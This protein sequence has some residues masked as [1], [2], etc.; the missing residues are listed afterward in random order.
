MDRIREVLVSRGP[1]RPPPFVVPDLRM[2]AVLV[3]LFEA[4]GQA[5]VLLT[6]RTTTMRHHQ[7]DVAFPGG[8]V[9]E[10]EAPRDAAL[11]EAQEEIGLEPSAVEI[12]GELDR[13]TTVVSRFVIVPFVGRLP[14]RPVTTPNPAEIARVFDVSL[15]E[16][17]ADG[18][19][20]QEIWDMPHGARSVHFFEL[21][22]ETVWGAT[23]R[24]LTQ[25]LN[26]LVGVDDVHT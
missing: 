6:R 18:V 16:L 7:G 24:M 14:E 3:P 20:H 2:A 23:A 9:D 13:L 21:E 22:G 25:L 4:D 12:M 19:H 5:R 8:R 15:G 10:G 26:W 11:R 1:G 17:V